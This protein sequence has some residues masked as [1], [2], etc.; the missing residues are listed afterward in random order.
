MNGSRNWFVLL[1]LG[2]IL[3]SCA[4]K[5]PSYEQGHGLIAVPFRVSNPTSYQLIRAI[6]LKSSRDQSFSLR[7]EA[8]PFNDDVVFSKPI[9]SGSYLIDYYLMKVVPVSGVNDGL[10]PSP[11]PLSTPVQV[12]IKD[13]EL[14]VFPLAFKAAQSTR[15][16]YIYCDFSYS[17]LAQSE[18]RYYREKLSSLENGERWR[19]NL[20]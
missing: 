6:E 17:P 20:P 15:A 14:F 2:L 9:P 12:A 4:Q 3:S 1:F 16:D 10:S 11:T 5:L 7:L 19:V 13:G 18:A 8:P